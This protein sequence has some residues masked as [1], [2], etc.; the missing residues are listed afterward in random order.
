MKS[1]GI[2]LSV[3]CFCFIVAT[4]IMPGL[5]PAFAQALTNGLVAY[6]PLD[7][8]QGG[9]TPD[10]VSTTWMRGISWRRTSFLE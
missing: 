4:T 8:L 1:R 9:K 2:S 7:E 5:H 3:A 6:W 10:V